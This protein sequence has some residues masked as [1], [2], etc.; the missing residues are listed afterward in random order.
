MKRSE[1][2]VALKRLVRVLRNELRCIVENHDPHTDAEG[3]DIAQDYECFCSRCI[4]VRALRLKPN[5]GVQAPERS[6]GS[7]Q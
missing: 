3:N 2:E 7:L 1:T 6:G 4:A 5:A